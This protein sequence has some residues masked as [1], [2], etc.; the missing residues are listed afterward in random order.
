M[1]ALSKKSKA[2]TA[3]RAAQQLAVI[4][5]DKEV[6]DDYF[7]EDIWEVVHEDDEPDGSDD[8]LEHDV[9]NGVGLDIKAAERL[10][11]ME[12]RWNAKGLNWGAGTSRAT[13]YRQNKKQKILKKTG[14]SHKLKLTDYFRIQ[15]EEADLMGDDNSDGGCDSDGNVV[16]GSVINQSV[17]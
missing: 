1:P 6:A 7:D 13:Y 12:T 3:R 2:A 15:R 10:Q 8:D 4:I 14:E 17:R 11:V 5:G 16:L 9:M